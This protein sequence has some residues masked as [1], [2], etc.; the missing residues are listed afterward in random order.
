MNRPTLISVE[1]NILPNRSLTNV[2]LINYA[3][4][5]RILLFRGVFVRDNL[6]RKPNK[7]ECGV[8]NLDDSFG[9]GT[10]WVSWYR[11]K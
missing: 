1:G 4:K 6:P 8:L 10:H 2:E 11:K 5:R 9:N 7:N 3:K